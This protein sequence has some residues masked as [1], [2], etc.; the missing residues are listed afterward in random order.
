MSYGFYIIDVCEQS[1][2][3][4]QFQSSS[5]VRAEPIDGTSVFTSDLYN[6][7][8]GYGKVHG[9]VQISPNLHVSGKFR[10]VSRAV[11]TFPA[12]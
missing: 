9:I 7:V 12:Q 5:P 1:P 3:I 6:H 2:V 11:F 10:A 8:L 4:I